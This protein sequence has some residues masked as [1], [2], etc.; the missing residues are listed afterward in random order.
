MPPAIPIKALPKHLPTPLF[1]MSHLVAHPKRS[2][3]FSLAVA[4]VALAYNSPQGFGQQSTE[5]GHSH[6]HTNRLI[7]E[8]SPY[9]LQHAHNPVD[10]YPW[11]EEA[12]AKAKEENKPIF[13]SVGYSTCYWCHVMEKESFEDPDVAKVI[14]EHFI[15]IKVDREERPDIDEQYMLAT[16]LLTSRGGWPNSVWLTPDGDPWM[17]GTYFPKQRFIVVLEQLQNFWVNR[18][19]DV[20]RQAES[21]V[22]ATE[23][24]GSPSVTE[25]VELSLEMVEQATDEFLSQFDDVHGGFGGAPKFPPHGTLSFLMQ[26]YRTTEN[27]KILQAVTRTLDAMWLGGF[28]DHIGGGFHRYSTDRKWLLPHFEKMLYDNAQLMDAYAEAYALTQKPRYREA[29]ADIYRWVNREMTSPEGGFYSAIDSGEVGKEGE[30]LIW[31]T[32]QLEKPLNQEDADLFSEVYQFSNEGNFREEASGER[33]GKNIPY[34]VQSLDEIAQQ[35]GEDP[36]DFRRRMHAIRDA[37]LEERLHWPQPHKDDKILTSWNGLMIKSLAKAGRLLDEPAYLQSAKKAADFLVKAMMTDEGAMRSFRNG[38]AKQ[39]GFLDD[40]VFLAAGLS[41]LAKATGEDDYIFQAKRL[42]DHLRNEFEDAEEGGFFQTGKTHQELLVRSKFLGSGGNLP[43]ANGIAA[44]LM[45]ELSE[46]FNDP[47]LRR[48]AVK[49]LNAFAVAID[50]QAH[51]NEDL[52]KAI[53]TW[54]IPTLDAKPTA[55]DRRLIVRG[56]PVTMEARVAS[57]DQTESAQAK[58]NR[59]VVTVKID[60][61]FHLY[62]EAGDK[63]SSDAPVL[64]RPVRLTAKPG[65][66]IRMQSIVMPAATKKNDPVL[67]RELAIYS[68]TLE[69]EIPFSIEPVAAGSAESIQLELQFQ[70]CDDMRCLQPQTL[71]GTLRI[72]IQ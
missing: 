55:D 38:Q 68:G 12:F 17:A 63:R 23:Q 44:E 54:V 59:L 58:S 22:R 40:H 62:G 24:A 27:P 37:L 19:D 31:S 46:E 45:F 48:S 34:R 33:I 3:I 57:S 41:E 43:N 56:S 16:Q 4:F 70:A 1:C 36:K 50:R 60:P 8:T 64:V 11:G 67:G 6:M 26:R 29:V 2:V 42:I 15:A 18:R 72:D 71:S 21:I 52:L 53:E 13:L 9:L 66:A 49:T 69:I 51:T 28:H 14:N 35:Y 47:A 32:E 10:W 25:T 5:Q 7:S 65:P 39:P 61:G 20:N 30:S